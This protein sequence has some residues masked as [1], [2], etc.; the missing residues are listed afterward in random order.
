MFLLLC[1]SK[2]HYIWLGNSFPC[3]E[4]GMSH[5]D[6]ETDE[7]SAVDVLKWAARVQPGEVT[8]GHAVGSYLLSNPDVSVET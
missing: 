5:M 3:A 6:S 7:P 1:P 8:A 2:V 4:A